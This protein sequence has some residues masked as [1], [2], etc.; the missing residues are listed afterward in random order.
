MKQLGQLQQQLRQ[1]SLSIEQWHRQQ[2]DAYEATVEEL[3]VERDHFRTKPMGLQNVIA[4]QREGQKNHFLGRHLLRDS[5]SAIR[6]LKAAIVPMLESYGVESALD[7]DHLKLVGVPGI[8]P[9]LIMDLMN[10]REQVETTF[11]FQPDHGVTLDQ[12]DV[13]DETTIRR[14]RVSQAR[15]V[16]MG[17]KQLSALVD[18]RRYELERL[19]NDY[20]ALAAEAHDI[21]LQ[22]RDFQSRRRRLE[23]WL[24]RS[25][26]TTLAAAIG[27]PLVGLLLWLVF[28]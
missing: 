23:H 3:R 26:V 4:Y 27:I 5:V 8:K 20:D 28:G 7:V 16:L 10:W 17:A 24:N 6:S 21:S 1:Q 9:G 25:P 22:L 15:R 2:Q 12:V 18:S 13:A 14:F 11:V 19:L